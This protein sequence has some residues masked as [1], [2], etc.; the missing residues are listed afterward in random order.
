MSYR[1]E[2]SAAKLGLSFQAFVRSSCKAMA[3]DKAPNL[4]VHCVR[5]PK[6]PRHTA[7]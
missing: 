5:T 3:Q 4:F 6:S 1:A 2:V 7:L